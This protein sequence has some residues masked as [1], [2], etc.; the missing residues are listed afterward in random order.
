M[1]EDLCLVDLAGMQEEALGVEAADI[2]KP[3][4]DRATARKEKDFARA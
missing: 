3:I 4:A 2:E 1:D